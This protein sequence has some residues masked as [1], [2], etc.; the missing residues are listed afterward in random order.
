MADN[1]Q[2]PLTGTGTA[3]VTQKTDDVGGAHVPYVK[4]MDGT[5]DGS[6]V[7][8]VTPGGRLQVETAAKGSDDQAFGVGT[9]DGYPMFALADETTPDSVDEG[10][11]GILRMSLNRNLY[12]QLRDGEGNERS[13][14]VTANGSLQVEVDTGVGGVPVVG[15]DAEG[16]TPVGS[17]VYIAAKDT[18]GAIRVPVLTTGGILQAGGSVAH[19]GTDSGNPLKLGAKAVEFGATPTAV[20][21]GQRTDLYANRHGVLFVMGGHPNVVST[22]VNYTGAQS[23]AAIVTVGSGTRIVVTQA[24]ILLS[25][26][27]TATPA[28]IVG[29]GTATTPTG[30]GVIVGHPG[31][32]GGGGVSRGDGS[33]IITIG[34]DGE[35]IRI[36]CDAPTG[37]SVTILISYY[38]IAA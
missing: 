1:I 15:T 19:G 17:P 4:L 34:A 9:D 25:T 16:V 10:D 30:D 22:R 2:H 3:D 31:L 35:D 36:T 11:A 20:S 13:A 7:V 24:M 26:P 14:F 27:T 38:L 8:G 32:A 18:A 12:T 29:F 23:N 33:G 21:A 5:A 37:G 6:T 28:V